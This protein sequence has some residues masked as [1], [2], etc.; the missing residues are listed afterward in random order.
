M[1]FWCKNRRSNRFLECLGTLETKANL[2]MCVIV[3]VTEATKFQHISRDFR[4]AVSRRPK[5]QNSD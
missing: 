4:D 1:A 3:C 5:P 2:K